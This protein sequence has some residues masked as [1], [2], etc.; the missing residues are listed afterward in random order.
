MSIDIRWHQFK[1]EF[2]KN[3]KNNSRPG[4]IY[5]RVLT[6]DEI[7]V[8]TFMLC[9]ANFLVMT[10]GNLKRKNFHRK[11]LKQTMHVSIPYAISL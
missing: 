3:S 1:F 10:I 11:I 6:V 9:T 5:A 8:G 2:A 4:W 7:S